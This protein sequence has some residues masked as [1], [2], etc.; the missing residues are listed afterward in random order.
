MFVRDILILFNC[1]I[2]AAVFTTPGHDLYYTDIG[3]DPGGVI[4]RFIHGNGIL[5]HLNMAL[6]MVYVIVGLIWLFSAVQRTKP[7]HARSRIKMVV[8]AVLTESLFFVAENIGIPGITDKYDITMLGYFFATAIMLVAILSFNLLGTT[9]LAREFIIDRISEAI[10]AVDN[11]GTVKYYNEPAKRLYPDLERSQYELPD[12]IRTAVA[13]G[14]TICLNDRIYT[15]E[16]NPLVNEGEQVGRIYALIDDTEHYRYLDEL[17]KQKQLIEEE[18]DRQTKKSR[19]L[20]REMMLALSKTVDTKDH[21]TDGHSRRVAAISAE[22][23]RRLGMS[24][25]KQVILYEIGLLHD[26]GKIGIHEDIIHK[27]SGLS[28]DEYA[29]IKAHTLKG[30]EILKEIADMP[31]LCEGARWHHEK[32]DG[33]GYPDGLKGEE[34]PLSARIVCIADCY[35]AMTSTR[36]YSVP[37]SQ[38]E[39][40]MEIERCRGTW[41]DPGATDVMLAMIDEDKEYRMNEKALGGDVWKEYDRLWDKSVELYTIGVSR[42]GLQVDFAKEEKA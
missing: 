24:D 15:P 37:R 2:Y 19:R 36:T 14:E 38:K 40:R 17:K 4:P 10:V 1:G 5:H 8:L 34:I 41:F 33:R 31:K 6:Q 22:I 7:G 20:T 9:E 25:R 28:D 39:V 18:V 13:S 11:D 26:I 12:E 21:Y 42:A 35:D 16:E 3:F 30:Y 23:G 29:E 27:D 32:Y